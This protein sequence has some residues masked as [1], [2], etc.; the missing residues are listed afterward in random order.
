MNIN[1]N[2]RIYPQELI[3]ISIKKYEFKLEN[4]RKYCLD[5]IENIF[6]YLRYGD[7]LTNFNNNR[8]YEYICTYENRYYYGIDGIISDMKNYNPMTYH[9]YLGET[10]IDSNIKIDSGKIYIKELFKENTIENV[11]KED[12]SKNLYTTEDTYN[13]IKKRKYIQLI[14]EI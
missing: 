2:G 13:E 11:M 4:K 12:Y 3:D 9:I 8:F 1:R 7:I 6:K 14:K 10:E 5:N